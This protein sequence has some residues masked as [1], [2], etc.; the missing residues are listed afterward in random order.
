MANLYKETISILE[1]YGKTFTDVRYIQNSES[2]ITKDNFIQ[3]AKH[4][5][6]RMGGFVKIPL[7]LV[8]VGENWWL[9][10]HAF[11]G[12]EWWE[13]KERPIKINKCKEIVTLD[14]LGEDW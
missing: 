4:T 12:S 8:I 1:K 11:D 10:R 14:D 7:N 9:E 2:Q 13:Y 5:N 6:Y 3:V